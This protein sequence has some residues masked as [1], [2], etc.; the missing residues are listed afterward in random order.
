MT[1]TRWIQLALV[2]AG[3][4]LGVLAYRVQVDNLPLT[5]SA[6]AFAT[7]LAA[8]AFLGAATFA[9]AA[10]PVAPFVGVVVVTAGAASTVKLKT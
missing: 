5:T 10:T 3:V 2:V 7:V 8:W 6:R 4:V 1:R 9:F